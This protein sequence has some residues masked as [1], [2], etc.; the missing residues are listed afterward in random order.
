MFLTLD[1]VKQRLLNAGQHLQR[2]IIDESMD[3]PDLFKL[4]HDAQNQLALALATVVQME[5]DEP[6]SI[7]EQRIATPVTDA[8]VSA[9]RLG[10]MI[11]DLRTE[12]QRTRP[13]YD[14]I[15]MYTS[16][17]QRTLLRAAAM[18]E[19]VHRSLLDE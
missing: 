18:L 8:I 11:S 13:G 15:A 2:A 1:Y 5:A 14:S 19:A 3:D 6:A 12:S 10:T 16:H 7:N 4:V 17:E 9:D